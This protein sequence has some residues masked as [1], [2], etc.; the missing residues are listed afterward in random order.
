[1]TPFGDRPTAL[2]G[3]KIHFLVPWCESWVKTKKRC[4]WYTIALR[5]KNKK[6]NRN[7]CVAIP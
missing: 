6:G 4:G 2:K 5:E 3:A 7:M 1:M